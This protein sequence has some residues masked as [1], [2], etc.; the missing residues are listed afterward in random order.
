MANFPTNNTFFNK[1]EVSLKQRVNSDSLNSK[2]Q[3][4]RKDPGK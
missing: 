4:N 3:K 1:K 2:K